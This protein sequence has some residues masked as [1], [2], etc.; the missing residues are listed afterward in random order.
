MCEICKPLLDC[1][2]GKKV[3]ITLNEFDNEATRKKMQMNIVKDVYKDHSEV[4]IHTEFIDESGFWH[5][6]SFNEVNFCPKCGAK[7]R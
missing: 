3:A 7:L 2:V 5:N 4:F 1:E 6:I